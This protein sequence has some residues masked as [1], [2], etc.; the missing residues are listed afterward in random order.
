MTLHSNFSSVQSV[1]QM[2]IPNCSVVC[3]LVKCMWLFRSSYEKWSG[4]ER[5]GVY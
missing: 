5:S 2:H 1:L 3:G 4:A